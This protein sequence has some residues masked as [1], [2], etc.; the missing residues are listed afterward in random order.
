MDNIKTGYEFIAKNNFDSA[1][2]TFA[3]AVNANSKD[4][5][6]HFGLAQAYFFLYKETNASAYRQKAIQ[7]AQKCKEINPKHPIILEVQIF[8]DDINNSNNTEKNTQLFQSQTTYD[9]KQEEENLLIKTKEDFDKNNK[10]EEVGTIVLSPIKAFFGFGCIGSFAAFGIFMFFLMK[11]SNTDNNKLTKTSTSIELPNK[12]TLKFAG[13]TLSKNGNLVWVIYQKKGSRVYFQYT[14]IDKKAKSQPEIYLMDNISEIF[15]YNN[16]LYILG[17]IENESFEARNM[18]TGGIILNTELLARKYPALSVE[19][20][21]RIAKIKQFQGKGIEIITQ[22]GDQ[23][24]YLFVNQKLYSMAEKKQLERNFEDKSGYVEQ[25]LW[26]T[27]SKET[28]KK[29]YFMAKTLENPFWIDINATEN[30]LPTAENLLSINE[31]KNTNEFQKFPTTTKTFLEGNLVYGDKEYAIIAHKT[32]IGAPH[33]TLYTCIE[34]Q[35]GK[36][37]WEKSPEINPL[38]SIGDE[39]SA[40]NGWEL[41]KKSRYGDLVLFYVNKPTPSLVIINLKTGATQIEMRNLF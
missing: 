14:N 16:I 38:L 37:V 6:A 28:V 33:H 30:I 11:I 32:H 4:I 20:G 19:S 35:T 40:S 2:N 1:I 3:N 27:Q 10:K 25:Y 34:A 13:A 31:G 36:V 5:E 8:L 12:T 24:Y 15:E 29:T 9:K 21:T 41:D 26:Y 7:Y 18:E 23:F 17:G 22:K 39:I